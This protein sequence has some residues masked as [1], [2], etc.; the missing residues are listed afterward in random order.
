MLEGFGYYIEN[1]NTHEIYEFIACYMRKL[2]PDGVITECL[3]KHAGMELLD[4]IGPSDIAYAIA[5]VKN[6][7]HVWDQ[8]ATKLEEQ[9]DDN[10]DDD[11][12]ATDKEKNVL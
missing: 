12:K 4:Y 9:T 3:R 8:E 10:D 7:R 2:Y 6:S 5:L 1:K 11:D